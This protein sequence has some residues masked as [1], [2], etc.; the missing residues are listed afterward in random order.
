MRIKITFLR[1]L[2]TIAVIDAIRDLDR[3]NLTVADMELIPQT[4]Q[5][6]GKLTGLRVHIE[7]EE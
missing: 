7:Q 2:L 1:G 4:E 5:L 6:L 3:D